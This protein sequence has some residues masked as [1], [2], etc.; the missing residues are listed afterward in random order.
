[1]SKKKRALTIVGAGIVVYIL[2]RFL[3]FIILPLLVAVA[4]GKFL[5]PGILF[6]ERRCRLPKLFSVVLP[7]VVFFSVVAV[8]FYFFGSRL[9]NQI[10]E[11]VKAVFAV[12]VTVHF[13]WRKA[14][15]FAASVS[16]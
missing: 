2:F 1:M 3:F 15:Y 9:C 11:L 7:V 10:I 5:A 14:L 8:A 12:G 6:L 16:R 13:L 4:V